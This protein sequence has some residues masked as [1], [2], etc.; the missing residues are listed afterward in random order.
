MA[1][2]RYNIGILIGCLLLSAAL[3]GYVT[4]ARTTED[5]VEIPLFV[6][7]PP[8][9]ALLS[10]VPRTITVRVRGSGLQI[11]NMKYLNKTSDCRIDL[12][13][14]RPS[15]GSLYE[16]ERDDLVR[17]TTLPGA[18][19]IVSVTPSAMVLTTGDLFRKVVPVE[20][21]SNIS[22]RDG[23][24]VVGP[25]IL[26]PGTVEVR[27]TRSIVESITSWRTLKVSMDD[28]H[29][30]V[31]LS[32]PVNDSLMTVLNVV[33]STLTVR[34]DVQQT[35]E[36]VVPDVEIRHSHEGTDVGVE[37]SRISVTVQ[38][39]AVVLAGLTPGQLQAMVA[40][41]DPGPI[42]PT[43][44]APDGVRVISTTPAVVRVVRRTR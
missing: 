20:F 6:Q 19:S 5:E 4:L 34:L 43:V 27:G 1:R 44:L 41:S 31:E 42:K 35:A 9:Q 40:S 17:S 10:T 24:E 22:C 36:L 23:F 28:V 30:P 7:A 3:W 8:N 25:P 29:E 18:L 39:G 14:I 16:L 26:E 11:L 33:P 21:V 15:S 13:R 32:V 2:R 38:G 37:P 12:D